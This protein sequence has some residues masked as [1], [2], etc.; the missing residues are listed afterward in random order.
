MRDVFLGLTQGNRFESGRGIRGIII[1]LF[2]FE[3]LQ[4]ESLRRAFEKESKKYVGYG[5]YLGIFPF[6]TL[7]DGAYLAVETDLAEA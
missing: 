3:Y 1:K 6:R 2:F 4:I 7:G 5:R